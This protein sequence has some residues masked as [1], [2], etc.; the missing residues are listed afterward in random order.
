MSSESVNL[1]ARPEHIDQAAP[2]E[3]ANKPVSWNFDCLDSC[4]SISPINSFEDIA[5]LPKE[6]IL[7]YR[8]T[9]NDTEEALS[10]LK[11]IALDPEYTRSQ[12]FFI[13]KDAQIIGIITLFCIPYKQLHKKKY[14]TLENS[15]L[16]SKPILELLKFHNP[17]TFIIETGW[18]QLLSEYQNQK[19]G[20]KIVFQFL[21]P[22][23]KEIIAKTSAEIFVLCSAAGLID[24]KVRRIMSKQL[25]A[26]ATEDL[27]VPEEEYSKFGKSNPK[28]V[29]SSITAQKM[30]LLALQNIFNLSLGPVFIR[31]VLQ[32]EKFK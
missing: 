17:D 28:A 22:K 13:K 26:G 1:T 9:L 30:H 10:Y 11:G 2:I 6:L 19:L 24:P 27:K 7:D 29:F 15:K 32:E 16:I 4:F 21:I 25:K 14:L 3:I 12:L 5:S 20:T 23:I 8:L 18:L 31:K